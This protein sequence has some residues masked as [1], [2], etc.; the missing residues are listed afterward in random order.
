MHHFLQCKILAFM[1]LAVK[2]V[3]VDKSSRDEPLVCAVWSRTASVVR[4]RCHT[5]AAYA[6]CLCRCK[7]LFGGV[8]ADSSRPCITT[9]HI[10]LI[11][12]LFSKGRLFFIFSSL[13]PRSLHLNVPLLTKVW[14][15]LVRALHVRILKRQCSRTSPDNAPPPAPPHVCPDGCTG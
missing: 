13:I 5:L 1:F 6:R 14:R 4:Q 12:F 11:S 7:A 2:S 3:P 9:L 10:S 8:A 15:L